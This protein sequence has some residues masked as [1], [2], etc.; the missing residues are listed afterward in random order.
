[1]QTTST[2][3]AIFIIGSGV[4][5]GFFKTKTGGFGKY[6]TTTLIL[7]VVFI[8]STLL[9]VGN[10]AYL[11]TLENISMSVLGFIVGILVNKLPDK[12]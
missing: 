1:M 4:L 9:A 10:P 7:L 12:D 6:T 3:A 2:F 8:F 5:I 11:D